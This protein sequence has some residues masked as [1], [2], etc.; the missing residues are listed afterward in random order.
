[1]FFTRI[2]PWLVALFCLVP[3]VLAAQV[4]PELRDAMR[5]RD[6]AV[7][8]ADPSTWDRLTA[9]SFT[10]VV[11]DGRMMTKAER[12]AELKKQKPESFVA[13]TQE[14]VNRFGDTVVRRFRSGDVWV[15]DV[16]VRDQGI[17]RVAAVQVTTAAKK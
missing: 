11:E 10:V 9:P 4:P 3:S 14:Q 15:L 16:W 13:P 17:W 1:M 8:K 6:E 7:A 5:A 12:L 2:C